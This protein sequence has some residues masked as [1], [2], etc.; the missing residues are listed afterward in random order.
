LTGHEVTS[1]DRAKKTVA[2]VV[3]KTGK[4]K[5]FSYDKLVIATGASPIR[6]NIPGMELGNIFTLWTLRD[7]MAIHEALTSTSVKKAVIVGA[8]LV[9]SEAA[10]ALTRKKLDVTL[11]DALP[12]PLFAVA[13]H[14]FG[15][16]LRSHMEKNGVKF[17]GETLL[18]ELKGCGKVSGVV[19]EK[20]DGTGSMEIEADIVVMSIGVRPNVELAKNAGLEMGTRAIGVDQFGRTSD[21]DIYAG[22]DCA[23][24]ENILTGK[25]VWQPMGSTANRQ[26][27]VIANHIAGLHTEKAGF[28]GV[29]GT[30]IVRLFDWSAG[31][32]GLTF[33]AAKEAGFLPVEMLTSNP[34]LPGFMPDAAMLFARL[35]ADQ[36]TR[37]ILGA[38]I[39]G[40]GR[41]DKRLDVIA[42]AI[43]GNMTVD[44]LADAD[45]AYAPPFSS[46]LDPITHSAN[47]LRNKM[48]GMKTYSPSQLKAKG[49]QGKDF[50]VLDVRTEKELNIFGTLPYEIR[51]IPLGDLKQKGQTVPQEREVVIVCRAGVRAWS[52]YS[53]LSRH[54]YEKIAVLEGGMSAWP[55]EIRRGKSSARKTTKQA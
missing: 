39:V 42:T 52:A 30:S 41:V 24:S 45:L 3:V 13:G 51:H 22:G 11:V 19:V 2:A 32:T 12:C 54:G 14:E 33:E 18:K 25:S 49:E 15:I 50:L 20:A 34:D 47:A 38:Q 53:I 46:A 55:Y 27:R 4:A 36:P 26:G 8:G 10:E 37:R 16:M 17:Y 43:K 29:Q 23:E 28:G 21:P 5:T 6:P 48:S 7:A 44:D 40:P 35:V 1:I 31:K 9:G